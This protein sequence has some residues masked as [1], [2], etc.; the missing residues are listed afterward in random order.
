M[1]ELL[2]KLDNDTIIVIGLTAVALTYAFK[3]GGDQIVNTIIAGFIGY[4]RGITK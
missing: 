2:E 4:I 3:G 1:K